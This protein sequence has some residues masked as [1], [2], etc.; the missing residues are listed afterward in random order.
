M[1]QH[2]SVFMLFVRSSFYKVLLL[3]LAMIA[4]EGI[5]FYKT[6]QGMLEKNQTEGNFPV[7]TPEVVFEEAHL[8]VF[9]AVALILLTVILALVGRST[10][11]HQEYTWNRLSI[12]PKSIFLWQ[13]LYN[14]CCFLLL[15]FVQA[16]LA[17]GLCLY[18]VKTA[19]AGAVT[20]QSM[21]LAFYREPFLHG[22]IPLQHIW[23][24]V[25]NVLLFCS[26]GFAVAYDVYCSR[27]GKNRMWTWWTI[28]CLGL[29][30]FKV[31]LNMNGTDGMQGLIYAGIV[32]WMIFVILRMGEWKLDDAGNK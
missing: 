32:I 18:Y 17:F 12:T 10:T 31:D 22:L 6:I 21:F 16:A 7:M 19:D 29:V 4:A 25:R 5:W 27:R 3:L 23:Y 14:C 20:H 1:K 15:W 2:S 13:M 28:L 8:M 11:G 9:F 30:K 26:L 24:W